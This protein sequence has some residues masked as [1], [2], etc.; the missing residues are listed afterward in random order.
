MNQLSPLLRLLI[1]FFETQ[2]ILDFSAVLASLTFFYLIS[3]VSNVFAFSGSI[4]IHFSLSRPPSSMYQ[5]LFS[6]IVLIILLLRLFFLQ[7][8]K[9]SPLLEKMFVHMIGI[10]LPTPSRTSLSFSHVLPTTCI[11]SILHGSLF[12]CPPHGSSSSSSSSNPIE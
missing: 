2:M 6:P 10:L 5:F 4:Y 12:V 8:F 3:M 1:L 11:F 7:F 9:V